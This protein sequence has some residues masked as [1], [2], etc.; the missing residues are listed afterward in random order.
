M[1]RTTRA[2]EAKA[3]G[4][5]AK[6]TVHIPK[7]GDAV[8]GRKAGTQR[9]STEPSP[10]T[11]GASEGYNS[12]EEPEEERRTNRTTR[13][14]ATGKKGAHEP[15]PKRPRRAATHRDY[16]EMAGERWLAGCERIA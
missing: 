10:D 3:T 8:G 9:D 4:G 2:A 7:A 13:S 14:R 5:A 15:E 1:P 6:V 11:A 12:Q 16:K